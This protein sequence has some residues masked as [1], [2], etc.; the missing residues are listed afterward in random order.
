VYIYLSALTA[1]KLRT[2]EAAESISTNP[3][4]LHRASPPA[5]TIASRDVISNG[6]Q[7]SRNNR[8]ATARLIRNDDV[9]LEPACT[10]I[11]FGKI[12]QN[13]S[14][15]NSFNNKLSKYCW[16]ISVRMTSGYLYKRKSIN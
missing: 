14:Y 11:P 6:T 7:T 8:S 4:T 9:T 13:W 10:Q 3:A 16:E 15:M 12:C 2:D 1:V 5:Q